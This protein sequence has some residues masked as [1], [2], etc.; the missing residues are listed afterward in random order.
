MILNKNFLLFFLSNMTRV[1]VY[2]V[3]FYATPDPSLF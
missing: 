3:T 2:D 1:S